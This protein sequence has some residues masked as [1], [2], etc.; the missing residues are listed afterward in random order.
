M[1]TF[2]S[3]LNQNEEKL[4]EYQ[5]NLQEIHYKLE[6]VKQIEFKVRTKRIFKI[7]NS[8][9]HLILFI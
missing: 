6:K 9:K 5:S 1:F 7:I 3:K 8:F 2:Q 4:Y